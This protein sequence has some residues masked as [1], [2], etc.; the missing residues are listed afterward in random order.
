MM[1]RLFGKP[2]KSIKE[3]TRENRRQIN[4][5]VRGLDREVDNLKRQEKLVQADIKKALKKGDE[6]TAKILAKQIVQMRKQQERLSSTKGNMQA[7][8]HKQTAMSATATVTQ[9][10]GTSANI[11]GKMNAQMD[12]QKMTSTMRE[13]QKQNEMAS[14]KEDMIDDVIDGMFDDDLDDEVDDAV[15][16]ILDDIGIDLGNKLD[17]IS[18][19]RSKLATKGR[20]EQIDDDDAA[21]EEMLA[22]LKN[23]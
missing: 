4:G 19:G 10:M 9:A 8:S 5:N 22:K 3:Q 23:S 12:M 11:M 1:D 15:G 14:M 6:K 18:T 13:F 20:S 7:L 17:N 21:L 2:Q 16:Q